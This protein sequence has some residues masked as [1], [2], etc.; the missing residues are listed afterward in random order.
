MPCSPDWSQTC[1]IAKAGLECLILLPLLQ[2]LREQLCA[3]MPNSAPFLDGE[4][5]ETKLIWEAGNH[6]VLFVPGNRNHY[7]THR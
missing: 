3:S 4:I 7:G 2:V 1:C 5:K 6:L